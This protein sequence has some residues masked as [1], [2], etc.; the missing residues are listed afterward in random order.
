MQV[1][2]LYA[3][4]GNEVLQQCIAKDNFTAASILL[5]KQAEEA[6]EAGVISPY[7]EVLAEY[8]GGGIFVAL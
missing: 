4:N 2:K 8:L 7:A 5:T 3:N 6:E 1:W